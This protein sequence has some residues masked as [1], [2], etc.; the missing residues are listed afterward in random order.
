MPT[1]TVKWFNSRKGYGFITSGDNAEDIFVH[2][3]AI[4]GEDGF[5]T[6]H[7][8]DE[9]TYEIEDGEKGPQAAQVV[10]TKRAPRKRMNPKAG[11]KKG[12]YRPRK[13]S[14]RNEE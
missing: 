10:I 3:S 6:L 4:S 11:K 13:N 2:F 1:G 9:V 7:P 5:K 12:N 8:S 14:P